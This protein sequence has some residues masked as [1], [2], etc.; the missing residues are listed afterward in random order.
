MA[1]IPDDPEH[2]VKEYASSAE[3]MVELRRRLH[4]LQY[5]RFFSRFVP[6]REQGAFSSASTGSIN[7]HRKPTSRRIFLSR[8]SCAICPWRH[9]SFVTPCGRS[10]AASKLARS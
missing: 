1:Y 7:L 9:C 10:C 4:G 5:R 6:L 2:P 8:R 3:F